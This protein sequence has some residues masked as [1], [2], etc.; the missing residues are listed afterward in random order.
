MTEKTQS[1]YDQQLAEAAATYRK[2]N[3]EYDIVKAFLDEARTEFESEYADKIQ[4]EKERKA[5]LKEIESSLRDLTAECYLTL[6]EAP[7]ASWA[8]IQQRKAI[9]HDTDAKTT[10]QWLIENAPGLAVDLLILDEK[11]LLKMLEGLTTDNKASSIP[12][13]IVKN[14]TASISKTNLLKEEE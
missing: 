6:G 13:R 10:V 3:T 5:A 14:P 9:E 8:K 7:S 12:A 11:Q 4:A 2:A 1:Y